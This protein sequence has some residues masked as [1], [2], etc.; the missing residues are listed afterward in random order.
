MFRQDGLDPHVGDAIDHWR[1]W[2]EDFDLMRQLGLNA[3]RF[4]VAWSRIEPWP[5]RF[6]ERA[7]Q[8]YREMLSGLH[9]RGITPMLTLHH[10]AH[11]TWFHERGPWHTSYAIDAFMRFVELLSDKLL[12]RV[13]LIITFNEPLVWVLGAYGDAKL[14]PGERNL[15]QMM[16]ALKNMMIAHR[17]AYDLIKIKHPSAQ[18]GIAHNFMVFKRARRFSRIDHRLQRMVHQFYNLMLPEAF[19]SN[20][21]RFSFQPVMHYNEPI[22][23]DDCIDFWGINY[24]CRAHV[25]FRF[26]LRRPFEVLFLPQ[27]GLGLSDLGWETY[28]KGLRYVCNWLEFT[29]KPLYVTENGIA[30]EDDSVR[31]AY[32]KAHL[33]QISEAQQHGH[34]LRGYF[35][36]SLVDNY[37]WLV[38]NSARFGL[39]HVDYEDSLVRTLKPS[40]EFYRDHIRKSLSQSK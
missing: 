26:D 34:P 39:C 22:A 17:R 20:K 10:F 36:W 12:D 16:E 5:G 7:I 28:P 29:G 4:S 24:Y 33:E 2:K 18:I 23:L 37:E 11:P 21:L 6:D 38:G 9:D 19:L 32:L 30:A 1:R 13:P 15:V 27:G 25:R 14:P 35:H 3:Y 31:V 8:Q 40:A